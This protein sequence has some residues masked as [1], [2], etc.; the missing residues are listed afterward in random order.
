MKETNLQIDKQNIILIGF[1]GTGKSTVG[2]RLANSL[3]WSFLDTDAE[4]EKLT[5]LCIA[6][7]FKRHGETR[8]RSEEALLVKRLKDRKESVIA[9]G[10]GTVLNP[11]NWKEL[12]QYGIIIALYAPLKEIY[13]RI[14]Q[15][16]DRPLLKGSRREVEKLWVERQP[17][18]EKA[19]YVI[20]TAEKSIDEVVEE[21]ILVIKGDAMNERSKS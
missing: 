17:I 1:M 19:D 18:Y 9:T 5:G 8:F 13:E 2:K 12:S 4:I 3:G 7:I 11:E 6:D 20:D 16:N 15:R 10:G 14:G 21:I